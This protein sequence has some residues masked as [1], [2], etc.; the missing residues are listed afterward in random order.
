MI[1][2]LLLNFLKKNGATL[3][4]IAVL[5]VAGAVLGYLIAGHGYQQD[6]D[7]ANRRESQTRAEF[8][9]FKIS[10]QTDKTAEAQRHAAELASALVRLRQYQQEAETLSAQLLTK[11]SELDQARIT[12][13][14]TIKNVIEKDGAA[15]TGIGP[16]SLCAYR[17]SLGY[18]ECDQRLQTAHGGDAGHPAETARAA[19]GLSPAGILNSASD[20]GAWCQ[21][22]EAKLRTLKMF[23]QGADNKEV[24]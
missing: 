15:Y 22:L 1:P 8:D 3:V 14:R 5:M 6:I 23:Y 17:A 13:Q 10:T 4:V 20:Y 11:Q 18:P 12:F 9:A 24:Q 7:Q 19:G 21:T 2:S 16:R